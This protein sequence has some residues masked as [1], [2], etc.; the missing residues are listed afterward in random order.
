[1][2]GISRSIH[3][4]GVGPALA[5]VPARGGSKRIP[6]KNIR[7]FAGVPLLERALRTVFAAGVFDRV[8]VSTDD[9]EIAEVARRAGAEVPFMR[10][11]ALSDDHAPTK[12]VIAHAIEWL[13]DAEHWRPQFVCCAYPAAVIL[14]PVEYQRAYALLRSGQAEHVTTVVKYGHPVERAMRIDVEGQWFWRWPEFSLRRTQDL[15]P[16]YHDAGQFY[17]ARTDCWLGSRV[18]CS[19]VPIIVPRAVAQDIDDEED[20]CIAEAL[21][22]MQRNESLE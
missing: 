2:G 3:V 21:F 17:F 5:V 10:P 12:D 13:G 9:D 6:R 14:Q 4:E 22:R 16:S 8:V 20:W 15:D 18:P 19:Q 1:M 7:P 11:R